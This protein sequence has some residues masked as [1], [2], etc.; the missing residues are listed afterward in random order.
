[1]H[2]DHQPLEAIVKKPLDRAL[3]LAPN[4][5][6]SLEWQQGKDQKIADMLSRACLPEVDKNGFEFINMDKLEANN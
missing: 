6:Y 4:Y 3:I 1:M 5:N 2:N